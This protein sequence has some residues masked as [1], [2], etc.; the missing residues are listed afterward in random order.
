MLIYHHKYIFLYLQKKRSFL[1]SKKKETRPRQKRENKEARATHP[2]QVKKFK[3][4]PTIFFWYKYKKKNRSIKKI[5]TK[6]LWSM[7]SLI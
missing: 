5:I 4:Y 1:K 2:R 3:R 6:E 7:H